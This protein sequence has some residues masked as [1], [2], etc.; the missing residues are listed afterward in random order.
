M[1]AGYRLLGC[2]G[3]G[4]V[5]VEAALRLAELPYEYEEVDYDQP[6]PARDRLLELNP[7]GQVPTLILPD[8]SLMTESAAIVLLIDER[9][10]QAGL[11]PAP[12]S[13]ERAAFLRWLVF[14]VAA[15]YPT[16]TY[17]DVANKW[18]PDA[19][20]AHALR[21]ATDRHRERLWRQVEGAAQARPWFL[22]ER[23]SA[24]DIYIGAMAYWRPRKDWFARECPKLSRIA[25][26]SEALPAL[27][28]LFRANYDGE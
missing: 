16:F 22:G 10:P 23:F 9:R 20:A 19:A 8:G 4:S 28:P 14:L 18:L 13:D 17:G 15:I 25:A 26:A 24:L 5:I 11:A 7:L 6:G 27:T 2:R 3:C 12:Q 1:P 21:E